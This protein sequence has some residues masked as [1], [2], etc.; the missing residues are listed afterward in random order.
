M[1]G[2]RP[3]IFFALKISEDQEKKDFHVR[4]CRVFTENIGEDQQKKRSSLFVM[5]PPIFCEALGFGLLSLY[6]NPVLPPVQ[7]KMITNEAPYQCYNV[8]MH[9]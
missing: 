5:R 3:I 2:P 6:V 8:L 7:R 4:R 1:R 9:D